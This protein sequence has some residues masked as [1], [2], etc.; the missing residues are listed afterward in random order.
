MT[1]VAKNRLR[2]PT[3]GRRVSDLPSKL[4]YLPNCSSKLTISSTKIA[5]VKIVDPGRFF[6]GKFLFP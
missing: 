5:G 3:S 1:C 4:H 6:D 2:G